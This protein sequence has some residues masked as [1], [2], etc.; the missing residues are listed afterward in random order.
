[1]KAGI[2]SSKFCSGCKPSDSCERHRRIFSTVFY[3]NC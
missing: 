3:H 1:V 2:E